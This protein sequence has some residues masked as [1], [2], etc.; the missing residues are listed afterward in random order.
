MLGHF[1]SLYPD[2]LLYSACARFAVRAGY[3]S[4]K[5]VL[6]EL[7]GA[8]TATAI[9]D[10]PNRLGFLAA[11]LPANSS[12]TAD[13]LIDQHTLLPFFSAFQ[14]ASRIEQLREDLKGTHGPAGHMRSGIMASRNPM[15][16]HLR[17]C[18]LC[19]QEDEDSFGE[20]YW[21]RLHQLPSVVV[22][23]PHR[24]FLENS[25]VN[26]RAGRR[27][28]QFI[29]AEQI[30]RTISVRHVDKE[31]PNHH[32][33]LQIAQDAQWLLE[34]P[35]DSTSLKALHIRYLRL[36]LKR[37]IATYTGSIRVKKLLNGFSSFYSPSL[38]KL[39]NCELRGRDIEKANWLLR[40]VRPPKHAQH[41]LYH[42][43]LIQFLGYTVEEFFQLPEEFHPFGEGPW[44]CLNP[45]AAHYRRPV[46]MECQ[47]GERLRYGKPAGRFSCE[48]GFAYVRTGPDS[49]L[50]DRFRVGKTISFGQFWEAKLTQLWNDSTLSISEI[51]RRLGVDP[52]TIRRH[53][54]RLK[55]S[56][57]R[58]DKELKQLTHSTRLKGKV[59]SAAWEKKRCRCRYKW[60]SEMK[61]KR[62][63]TLKDLRCKLPHEYAWLL[64]NDSEWLERYKPH[65][66]RHSLSTT[67]VDWKRRD[68]EHAAA[69]KA[70][71]S[72]LKET[73]GRLVRVT[74]TAIGREIGAV[75]LLRQKLHKMPITAQILV[76][77]VETREAYAVRRIWQASSLFLQE[78]TVPREWQLLLRAGAFG[79]RDISEVKV[80][81]KSAMDFIDTELSTKKRMHI[82]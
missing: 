38:L 17:F 63:I 22:C 51:G 5:S 45:A 65:P 49:S 27:H 44:P 30:T 32:R 13:R 61:Q 3:A 74:K 11:A 60:L 37:G 39:L 53:A 56:F 77:V 75:S 24:A 14:P 50:I 20:T 58:S 4:V 52:L 33:L 70:A 69:V 1:P 21:H 16:G 12:L 55:L 18:P 40:L 2:E 79:L 9:I 26:L 35:S 10:L 57:S 36:L 73:P 42:L 23:S 34:H 28:L 81:I 25:G 19:K 15:P 72:R 82:S 47:L 80:A 68:A 6:D 48:C 46:I 59:V 76:K 7:F 41:P 67:S 78:N 54:T 8:P 71:A 29:P 43:L 62:E 64:Q 31:D 66:W